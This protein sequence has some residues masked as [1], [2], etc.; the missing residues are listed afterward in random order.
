ML[1]S[2]LFKNQ[3]IY[4]Y[5]PFGKFPVNPV[6]QSKISWLLAVMGY[7]KVPFLSSNALKN[8]ES[9]VESWKEKSNIFTHIVWTASLV[10]FQCVE[11]IIGEMSH[12]SIQS[13][14]IFEKSTKVH[15]FDKNNLFISFIDC[16]SIFNFEIYLNKFIKILNF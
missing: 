2:R 1:S 16:R 14:R 9:Q 12:V 5:S 13:T 7:D 15:L 6:F 8:Y 4:L 11:K 10:Y 3:N